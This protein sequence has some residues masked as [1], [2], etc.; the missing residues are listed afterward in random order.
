MRRQFTVREALNQTFESDEEEIEAELETEG[1]VL[2]PEDNID[3]DFDPDLYETD[4]S[5]DEEAPEEEAQR[6]EARKEEAP[7]MTFQSMSCNLLWY[8]CSASSV[9][10]VRVQ[11]IVRMTPGPTRYAISSDLV[12]MTSSPASKSFYQSP[13]RKLY[14]T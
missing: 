14:W 12:W 3:P 10:G 6:E 5:T 7:E 11:N 8:S 2:E 9:L 1:E 4:Q 13:W